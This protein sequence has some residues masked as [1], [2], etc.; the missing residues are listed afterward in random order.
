[1]A[2]ATTITFKTGSLLRHIAQRG[3]MPFKMLNKLFIV[4]VF[5]TGAVVSG[6][7]GTSNTTPKHQLFTDGLE[8]GNEDNG[9]TWWWNSSH[10]GD[11]YKNI[12]SNI[13]TAEI[14]LPRSR[15]CTLPSSGWS[16]LY[17]EYMMYILVAVGFFGNTMSLIVMLRSS[18]RTNA[19]RLYLIVL[20]ISDSLVLLIVLL[21]SHTHTNNGSCISINYCRRVFQSFSAYIV[22]IIS[23]Q[24]FIMV[25]FPFQASKHDSTAHGVFHLVTAFIFAVVSS[26]YQALVTQIKTSG[27]WKGCCRTTVRVDVFIYAHLSLHV[28]CAEMA[29][30]ILVL[31]LTGITIHGVLTAAKKRTKLS[32][33]FNDH[34]QQ[35]KKPKSAA[36]TKLTQML[37][38]LALVFVLVRMPYTICYWY[39]YLM[40]FIY[41]R[42]TGRPESVATYTRNM[43]ST[44]NVLLTLFMANYATNFI[45]YLVLWPSFRKNVLKLFGCYKCRKEKEISSHSD[46]TGATSKTAI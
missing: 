27:P 1:M 9:E 4:A 17:Q 38:V 31:I 15:P 32:S 29:S 25:K 21:K 20:S 45:I 16:Q 44:I 2:V 41:W 28:F 34:E 24:R 46:T 23:I 12:T 37:I 35:Q 6:F 3:D 8:F 14:G 36:D 7:N 42:G 11:I 13:T 33:K 5:S 30:S 43:G 39:D 19:S 10:T 22:V 18:K 40:W 26:L